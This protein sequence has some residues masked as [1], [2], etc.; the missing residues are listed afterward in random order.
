MK[1]A[2]VIAVTSTWKY[3]GCIVRA[4]PAKVC[5][6]ASHPSH[7]SQLAEWQLV[8]AARTRQQ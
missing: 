1:L 5:A 2:A 6:Q 3:P 4:I 8:A 7:L